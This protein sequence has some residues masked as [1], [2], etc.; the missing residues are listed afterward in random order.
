MAAPAA[1]EKVQ[2]KPDEKPKKADVKVEDEDDEEDDDDDMPELESA[3]A[4]K[5]GEAGAK[6]GKQNRSEKKARKAMQ[7]LG[8][9]QVPGITRVTIKKAKNVCFV[10]CS[11]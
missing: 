11:L 2:P 4:S 1:A 8:M 10:F 5:G 6:G 9:K 7:K 3:D